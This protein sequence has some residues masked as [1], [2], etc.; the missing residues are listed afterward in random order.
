MPSYICEVCERV[1]LNACSLTRHMQTHGGERY[2]RCEVCRRRFIYVSDLTEHMQTHNG[3][4]YLCII[5]E[6]S[7]AYGDDYDTH[8]RTHT[9]EHTRMEPIAGLVTT[10]TTQ[11]IS[12]ANTVATL[13]VAV[14][15]HGN[16]VIATQS[17]A[18]MTTTTVSQSTGIVSHTSSNA[19]EGDNKECNICFEP[20]DSEPT[21]TTECNH[22]FHCK[23]LSNLANIARDETWGALCP[24]CR[25]AISIPE[26]IKAIALTDPYGA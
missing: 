17:T 6:R 12:S 15:Q 18:S 21:Y 4:G 14:S 1:F 25:K 26:D 20:L 24:L 9:G 19:G 16:A 11:T 2:P 7:F 13:S 10:M 22:T 23:C 3:R 5:C 8:M